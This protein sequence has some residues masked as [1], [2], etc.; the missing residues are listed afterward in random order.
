MACPQC[1]KNG[2]LFLISTG[3]E[4]APSQ[5]FRCQPCGETWQAGDSASTCPEASRS[6]EAV[7]PTAANYIVDYVDT[8]FRPAG[9]EQVAPTKAYN[10]ESYMKQG[11]ACV[12]TN[13]KADKSS[14]LSAMR[15]SRAGF[16]ADTICSG[17][18]LCFDLKSA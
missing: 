10:P 16:P 18:G 12:H 17:C 5:M 11:T 13:P 8:A 1:G 6:C 2:Q 15:A 7:R 3:Q 4:H 9:V 14:T